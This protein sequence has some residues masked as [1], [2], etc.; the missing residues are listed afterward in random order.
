MKKNKKIDLKILILLIILFIILFVFYFKKNSYIRSISK[1]T[2]LYTEKIINIP[3]S[4]IKKIINVNKIYNENKK[5]KSELSNDLLK[6]ENNNLKSELNELKENLSLNSLLSE[7]NYVSST[8]IARDLNT[9]NSKAIID[10]GKKNKLKDGLA[11]INKYGLIGYLKNC[12]YSFCDIKLLTSLSDYKIS[13]K[14]EIDDYYVYGLITGYNEK[15]NELIIEGISENTLIPNNSYVLT[16]GL[17]NLFPSGILIGNVIREEKDNFDLNR[18]I[19]VKPAVDFNDINYVYVL[20][21]E[22]IK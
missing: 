21:K 16:S 5:L 10:S 15:A 17:G 7:Y 11:V 14:V 18:T 12:S 20:N 2:V 1:D 9:W 4:Y 19:I 22:G 6:V 8:V 3:V 13:V